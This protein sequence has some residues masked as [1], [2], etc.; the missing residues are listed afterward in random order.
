MGLFIFTLVVLAVGVI[1]IA[2]T[3]FTKNGMSAL[4]GTVASLLGIVL[5]IVSCVDQVP[6]RNVGIVVAGQ[7]PTGRTTGAGWQTHKPWEHVDDWDAS[8]QTF[9]HL[10]DKDCIWLAIAAQRRAC[11]QVQ[12][13]WAAKPENAPENWGSYK[14]VGDNSRFETW[15]ARRVDPQMNATLAS[16]FAGFDPLSTVDPKS[17]DAPAP[18]LNRL[19]R[20]PLTAALNAAIG[21]D[22]IIKS[23]AFGN[24]IY[25]EKTQ[26][27]IDAFGQKI[28]EARNL[29]IDEANAK[30]RARI[31]TTDA[32]VDQ[33][34]R[35][36]QIAEKL[37]K[38]PGLC[39]NPLGTLAQTGK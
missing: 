7:K 35:C 34:A 13:E 8:G 23:V 39:M 19:Y 33:V 30:T 31:T 24:P 1:A 25:D 6:T 27:A 36:L 37:G 16:L 3:V 11:I 9:A 10:G 14:A 12:V 2:I 28:L 22:A 38:E 18:D 26:A 32:S 5:L 4:V 20:E 21:A 17:G 29:T 15:V